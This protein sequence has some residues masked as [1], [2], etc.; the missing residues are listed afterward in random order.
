MAWSPE[1]SYGL[2]DYDEAA[3]GQAV[4][5]R[6]TQL[7]VYPKRDRPGNYIASLDGFEEQ[8][9]RPPLREDRGIACFVCFLADEHKGGT[10]SDKPFRNLS[11]AV[12]IDDGNVRTTVL[13]KSKTVEASGSADCDDVDPASP[14]QKAR[15]AGESP[16][17]RGQT[18]LEGSESLDLHHEYLL[19]RCGDP[20]S[21]P[22]TV[23]AAA[24]PHG[25]PAPTV[26]LE[27]GV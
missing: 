7:C 9:E 11:G 16:I 23:A 18:N 1:N 4:I 3:T 2:R 10:L 26:L 22:T 17:A 19:A 15:H 8:L 24:T 21:K 6:R 27:R 5:A 13:E 25:G 14:E 12:D 20:A